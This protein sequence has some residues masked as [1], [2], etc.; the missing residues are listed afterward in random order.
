MS[1]YKI[2]YTGEGEKES[3]DNQELLETK[4]PKFE[5]VLDEI[6][7]KIVKF[8][9]KV[10]E[11]VDRY[12]L[13]LDEG[14]TPITYNDIIHDEF[15]DIINDK[16][17][18]S[19]VPEIREKTHYKEISNFYKGCNRIFL[20][21]RRY[22]KLWYNWK[23]SSQI[24]QRYHTE[25]KKKNGKEFPL[26]IISYGNSFN[27]IVPI[28]KL[29]IDKDRDKIENIYFHNEDYEWNLDGEDLKNIEAY[30][31][32]YIQEQEEYEKKRKEYNKRKKEHDAIER[33]KYLKDNNYVVENYSDNE[34]EEEELEE[35]DKKIIGR[36]ANVQRKVSKWLD[37]VIFIDYFDDTRKEWYKEK[38]TN[39]FL[40]GSTFFFDVNHIF[41]QL[42]WEFNSAEEGYRRA[43]EDFQKLRYID[44]KANIFNLILFFDPSVKD[45]I[46]S[47]ADIDYDFIFETI[48]YRYLGSSALRKN[49]NLTIVDYYY[50]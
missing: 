15:N 50:N 36:F 47:E 22:Y 3:A 18:N 20:Q 1:E 8:H 49:P 39:N 48:L 27:Y 45:K 16:S 31:Q 19:E 2:K 42:I 30:Q 26:N 46:D 28:L 40:Q 6:G 29:I 11:R 25:Q 5:H 33:A 17:T 44:S 24:E 14:E 13:E 4:I 34:E 35:E 10:I 9:N 37:N 23:N 7:Q 43:N 21:L 32:F 12:N 41:K 38:I